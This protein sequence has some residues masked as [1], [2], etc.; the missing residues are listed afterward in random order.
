MTTESTSTERSRS[1]TE[2][3]CGIV[4][5]LHQWLYL[6]QRILNL[7]ACLLLI[8]VFGNL[9]LPDLAV[10]TRRIHQ[11]VDIIY[12]VIDE[13][14]AF[15]CPETEI[16]NAIRDAFRSKW[17]SVERPISSDLALLVLRLLC[18]LNRAAGADWPGKGRY[19]FQ[20]SESLH[21][22]ITETLESIVAHDERF[23]GCFQGEPLIFVMARPSNG[24]DNR[25]IPQYS[26]P[27][28][29]VVKVSQETIGRDVCAFAMHAP[30]P[31]SAQARHAEAIL[32]ESVNI[33][34]STKQNGENVRKTA[35][36]IVENANSLTGSVTTDFHVLQF[37]TPAEMRGIRNVNRYT[38]ALA[39]EFLDVPLRWADEVTQIVR[40]FFEED[41]GRSHLVLSSWA[42]E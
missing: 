3:I 15:F 4:S 7:K 24:L 36:D 31:D 9:G 27:K 11:F 5:V 23:V 16:A 14:C 25:I 8:D 41:W 38:Q 32:R 34:E 2:G 30:K 21:T 29:P 22:R 42:W 26:L 33:T 39:K 37:F 35:N 19:C 6:I 20:L 40:Q 1:S 10:I 17:V 28:Q 18:F 13:I 12:S